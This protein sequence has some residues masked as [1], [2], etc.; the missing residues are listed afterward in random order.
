MN[1]APTA[2]DPAASAAA[3]APSPVSFALLRR[4]RGRRVQR[5]EDDFEALAMAVGRDQDRQAFALLFAFFAP[6][7]KNW[8]IHAG[9]SPAAADDL[10]QDTFVVFWR[11]ASQFDASK[12]TFAAWLFTITRNLRTDSRR[13]LAQ[14]WIRLDDSVFEAM[15]D[16]SLHSAEDGV[17]GRERQD[18][19]RRALSAL[20]PEQ[21]RLL[22][23]N[24]YED[25]SHSAIAA[26]L[27]MPLGTVKTRIRRAAARLRELLEEHRS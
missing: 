18:G 19:V 26:E 6:R 16:P 23:L 15:P 11:K 17:S 25:Q 12:A 27:K 21:R 24:Y 5:A 20:S 14:T 10:V 4:L 7:I 13:G 2:P 8:L 22:H 9:S 3:D 1:P